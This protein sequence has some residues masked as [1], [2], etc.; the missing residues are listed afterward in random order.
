MKKLL[1]F[2]AASGLLPAGDPAGFQIWTSAQLREK[3]EESKSGPARLAVWGNHLLLA[4]HRTATGE[5]EV[6]ETQAD[7]FIVE[8]GE[9][10]LIVGGSVVEGHTTAPNEI[11]GKS[12]ADGERKRLQAGDVVHIPAK[13]PHQL[14]LP[15]GGKFTY[16]VVKIDTPR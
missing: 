13:T 11:R 16:A 3:A 4:M 15:E 8:S 7:V 1:L 14:I 10:A 2:I 12:I 5:A 6:H 9:A